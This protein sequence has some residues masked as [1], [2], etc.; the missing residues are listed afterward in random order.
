[1]VVIGAELVRLRV[2]TPARKGVENMKRRERAIA[3]ADA[4]CGDDVSSEDLHVVDQAIIAELEEI[5]EICASRARYHSASDDPAKYQ[6][7][8]AIEEIIRARCKA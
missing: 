3:C 6:E 4:I 1:M 2:V 5:A 8:L 7:A